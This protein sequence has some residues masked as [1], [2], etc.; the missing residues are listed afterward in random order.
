MT[1]KAKKL[2]A[3]AATFTA[4][5]LEEPLGYW[6]RELG[7]QTAI[8]FAPYNQL[9][10]QLLDPSSLFCENVEGVNVAL[11]RLEDLKKSGDGNVASFA[12]SREERDKTERNVRDLIAALKSAAERSGTPFI[13]CLCP[14]SRVVTENA[15]DLAFFDEMEQLVVSELADAGGIYPVTTSELKTTYPVS[16]YNDDLTERIGNIPYTQVFFTA[17]ATMIARKIFALRNKPYKVIALDCDQTLWKGV[18]GE[19]GPCGIEIEGPHKALQEFMVAQQNAGMLLCLCSKNNESDVARVFDCRPEM[20]L[21]WDHLVSR[22]INWKSKPENL[23]CL[24]EQLQVGLDSFIFLDDDPVEC[25]HVRAECPEV[26]TL[27]LPKKTDHIPM[28]LKHVW[29][30]DHLNTTN[31]DRQ[32]TRLY[33]QRAE[34]HRFQ[35]GS[36]TF[37]DFLV[38]LEL[39]V[40]ISKMSDSQ[41]SRVA[42]LTQRTNQFNFTSVRRSESEIR[43]LC[44]SQELECLVVEVSDR[45]GNYGLVGLMMFRVG[46]EALEVDAFFLSCR[47]LGRG[48][49]YRM[50]KKLGEI[51]YD[52]G[53]SHINLRY[54]PTERN[55]PALDFLN[56]IGAEFRHQLD[57]GFLFQLPVR[58]AESLTYDPDAVHSEHKEQ[59]VS[60]S[61][62]SAITGEVQHKSELLTQIAIELC[63]PARILERI[64][65][66]KFKSCESKNLCHRIEQALK[67]HPA[68]CQVAVRPREDMPDGNRL[69]AYVEADRMNLPTISGHRR[70]LLPNNM[71]IVHKNKIETDVRY[72]EIFEDHVYLKHGIVINECDCVFDVGANIGMFTLFV[73]QMCKNTRIYAFEPVPELCEMLRINTALYCSNVKVFDTGLSDENKQMALTFH[74]HATGYSGYY[75]DLENDQSTHR[76]ILQRQAQRYVGGDVPDRY[77]DEMLERASVT[78]TFTTQLTTLSDVLSQNGIARINL[79]KIDVERSELDVLAGINEQDWKKIDQIVVEVHGKDLLDRVMTVLRSNCYQ[80]MVDQPAIL[81]NLEHFMLYATQEQ[82]LK[83]MASRKESKLPRDK[84]LTIPSTNILSGKELRVFVKKKLRRLSMPLDLM[85]LDTLPRSASGE[86]DRQSLPAPN[87]TNCDLDRSAVERL[88]FIQSALC[89]IWEEVLAIDSVDLYDDFFDIGG[90]SLL[91]TVVMSRVRRTFGVELPLLTIFKY[92]TVAELAQSIEQHLIGQLDPKDLTEALEKLNRLSDEQAREL[93]AHE[94]AGSAENDSEVL[95]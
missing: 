37:R 27:Q 42:Q 3:I 88:T 78:E 38:G 53:L 64:H 17:L 50:V 84:L 11:L 41:V 68:V 46:T 28:F 34:R 47:A 18:C 44:Q 62:H 92:P 32:R 69:V 72:E 24:A 23:K 1:E 63:D 48:V 51:A 6:M 80:V 67:R 26:L 55:Q 73:Q 83:A 94:T 30:F 40:N 25:A 59:S 85:F 76:S 77:V 15:G 16:D 81:K 14:A 58:S 65:R 54:V 22:R 86:V 56:G 35:E 31:E 33:K 21:G 87:R 43:R 95:L 45:F 71:A 79:L 12:S 49:E 60:D 13:V 61:A 75:P 90:Q 89:R 82:S 29:V 4:E 74:P 70:Y 91:G 36:M 20:P 19:D 5:L 66:W 39:K 93:L 52:R 7:M 57:D 10:H 2:I 9:F 8:E